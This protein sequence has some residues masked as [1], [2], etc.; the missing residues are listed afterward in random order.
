MG[1]DEKVA[2]VTGGGSGMGAATARRLG[3]LGAA[4][5]VADVNEQGGQQVVKEIVGAGGRAVFSLT[6]V[7]DKEAVAA[8]VQLA[9]RM[10]GRLDLAANVAGVPQSPTPLAETTVELWDKT[11][12]VN[13]RGLFFCL[14][15]EI[16]AMLRVGGGAIV[17]VSSLNGVRSFAQM[18]AYG[19]SKFGAVS[20]TMS[21][22]AEFSA[23]NVRVNGIAPGS[24]DT[25]MLAALP[26]ET[27]EHFA[28]TLPMKRLGTADEIANVI[29][30]LLSDEASYVSG[31]VI[32]V[33][34]G[35]MAS[36]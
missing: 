31:A 34:G 20:T 21:V 5:V 29:V 36:S 30:F 7:S 25:P 4:V 19:S 12:A 18:T 27:I 15:E 32:P 26:R 17:N 35:W 3:Q 23:Q 6:D 11:H 14:Q 1:F 8:M 33:D 2:V 22:A 10:F 28:S 13:D 16:P 9:E 24:I